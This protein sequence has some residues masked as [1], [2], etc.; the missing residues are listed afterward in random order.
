MDVVEFRGMEQSIV[1]LSGVALTLVPV[2]VALTSIIK[3]FITDTRYSPIISLVLGIA[4]ALALLPGAVGVAIVT[5]IVI[6]LTA[7]GLYSGAKSVVG[8]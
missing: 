1:Q 8:N 7:S 2:V 6:G 4:G 3:A 5:G